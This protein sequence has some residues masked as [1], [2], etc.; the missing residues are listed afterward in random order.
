MK[1]KLFSA[2]VIIIICLSSMFFGGI[3]FHLGHEEYSVIAER[4]ETSAEVTG[5]LRDYEKLYDT[6]NGAR[7]RLVYVYYLG[8]EECLLETEA[9]LS[10][11]P[12]IDSAAGLIC[13]LADPGWAVLDTSF[14]DILLMLI[15][16][17]LIVCPP[18]IFAVRIIISKRSLN[19]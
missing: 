2:A 18:V 6:Q 14:N 19:F 4:A 7:Y 8:G 13:D 1:Q 12:E 17:A 3:M 5:R 10:G 9:I 16:V 11:E 15:G